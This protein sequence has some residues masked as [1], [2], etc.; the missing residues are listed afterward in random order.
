VSDRVLL[1][2]HL[3]GALAIVLPLVGLMHLFMTEPLFAELFSFPMVMAPVLVVPTLVMLNMLVVW[4]L[5]E[6]TRGL[7]SDSPG[8]RSIA[9][10]EEIQ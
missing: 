1:F 6:R 3:T 8:M 9:G 10:D 4:R 7:A 2:W 5:F